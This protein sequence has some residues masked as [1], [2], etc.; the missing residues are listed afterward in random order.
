M[1]KHVTRQQPI[2]GTPSCETVSRIDDS[3][4]VNA[5]LAATYRFDARMYEL[6]SQFEAKA[7]ELRAS[8]LAE[9]RDASDTGEAA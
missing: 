2:F 7:S 9:L 6:R 8:F 5:A 4:G 1:N 3:D